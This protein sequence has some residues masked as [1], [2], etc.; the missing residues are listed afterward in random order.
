ML[1]RRCFALSRAAFRPLNSRRPTAPIAT[2]TA[3]IRASSYSRT[4]RPQAGG[5]G[6]SSVGS[7]GA[8]GAGSDDDDASSVASLDS[9]APERSAHGERLMRTIEG[10]SAAADPAAIA[11]RTPP[12]SPL[13]PGETAAAAA[14]AAA[15]GAEP[16]STR[17]PS[18]PPER[19][20]VAPALG[21]GA[22]LLR[23]APTDV[24]VVLQ[25][26]VPVPLRFV[27]EALCGLGS[28]G[29]GQ[30]SQSGHFGHSH[31]GHSGPAGAGCAGLDTANGALGAR[32]APKLGY[33]CTTEGRWLALA[34]EPPDAQ[35]GAA[36]DAGCA[37]AQLRTLELL[38]KLPPVPLLPAQTRLTV[39][40]LCTLP[41]Q[42]AAP[43]E[44]PTQPSAA[45][46]VACAAGDW[47]EVHCFYFERA[48][49]PL[50][51]PHGKH[52][53]LEEAYLVR[54][55]RPSSCPACAPRRAHCARCGGAG[56]GVWVQL[57]F[58]IAF[59][60]RPPMREAAIR[61]QLALR[62]EATARVLLDELAAVFAASP[63]ATAAVAAAAAAAAGA[64]LPARAASSAAAGGDV[65]G[66]LAA[67][68]AAAEAEARLAR[69]EARELRA[70]NGRL[71]ALCRGGAADGAA[72]ATIRRLEAQLAAERR[73]RARAEEEVAS[74]TGEMIRSLVRQLQLSEHQA[75]ALG[76]EY[77][78][79]SARVS[80]NPLAR[81]G[82]LRNGSAGGGRVQAV[83]NEPPLATAL[84][85]G[86]QH[87]APPAVSAHASQSRLGRPASAAASAAQSTHHL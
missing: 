50:D 40:H 1:A 36:R 22:S 67:R 11:L 44:P 14:A 37:R 75:S 26:F 10:D 34:A 63:E 19:S 2:L 82:H 4:P 85:K 49:Q 15:A 69:D 43:L 12:P 72:E 58:G 6:G 59:T 42:S 31:A 60:R 45:A 57:K 27:R 18:P 54:A 79:A 64:P 78:S 66:A 83:G 16:L 28:G 71:R 3:R 77:A 48:A 39:R 33:S 25:A 5:R 21:A 62:S 38:L 70:E 20:W 84:A 30:S 47:C 32:L 46:C 55:A 53:T 9:F 23:A 29:P 56:G 81:G 65:L 51:V 68:L 61:A 73:E 35:A 80:L 8:S 13:A 87:S 52:T 86:T 76:H 41:T 7:P 24:A 74:A 17:P